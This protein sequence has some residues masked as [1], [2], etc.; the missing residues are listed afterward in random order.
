MTTSDGSVN[1]TVVAE[2]VGP[3]ASCDLLLAGVNSGHVHSDR[4]SRS[5]ADLATSGAKIDPFVDGLG[6]PDAADYQGR[7]VA[8]TIQRLTL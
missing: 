2:A 7:P 5:G 4:P 1:A 8:A 3:I 6:A